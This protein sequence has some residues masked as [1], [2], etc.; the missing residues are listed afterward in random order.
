MRFFDLL[1]TALFAAALVFGGVG[2][3]TTIPDT[4]DTPPEVL[5][6]IFGTGIGTKR[7]SNPPMQNWTGDGGTQYF[8]LQAGETYRF[9]LTVS[10][11]G[12]VAL[13]RLQMFRDYEIF[14]VDG[15]VE[16]EGV[17][18]LES[19]LSKALLARGNAD[20]PRTGIL[21]FGKFTAPRDSIVSDFSA[22][23]WDFGGVGGGGSTGSGNHT[24]LVVPVAVEPAGD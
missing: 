17:E 23:G 16:G 22:D 15:G 7:M 13:A 5:L 20:D 18:V 11:A 10:D 1:A 8:N 24:S 21:I 12:G 9:R 3:S 14:D 4:D 2:C 6:E 19:G